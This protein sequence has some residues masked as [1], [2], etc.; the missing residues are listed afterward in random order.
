MQERPGCAAHGT[1]FGC[2]IIQADLRRSG[3][4]AGGSCTHDAAKRAIR[5]PVM[6][7]GN[8][9]CEMKTRLGDFRPARGFTFTRCSPYL[10]LAIA[11]VLYTAT[12]VLLLDHR[13]LRIRLRRRLLKFEGL[14]EP[15]MLRLFFIVLHLPR[16]CSRTMHAKSR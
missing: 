9:I 13:L 11:H 16:L 1:P 4:A 5:P 15:P 12:N 14:C 7:R 3:R 10:R 6:R 8:S 2:S